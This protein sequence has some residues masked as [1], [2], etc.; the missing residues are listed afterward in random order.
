VDR[1]QLERG[2]STSITGI[3]KIN[4]SCILAFAPLFFQHW[5]L[6]RHAAAK[7][8]GLTMLVVINNSLEAGW[9]NESKY[10]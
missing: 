6:A 2:F 5:I 3:L 8:Q 9:L 4:F 7:I 10:L 1:P